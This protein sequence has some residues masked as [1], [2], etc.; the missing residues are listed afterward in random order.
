MG[1]VNAKKQLPREGIK[2]ILVRGTNWIGD[3]VMTLPAVAAIRQTYPKTAITVLAKP[4]VAEIYR[5]S[6]DV[7]HVLIFEEPGLH[8]GIMGKFRIASMLKA[9]SFD[10]AILLQNA[11]EAAIITWLADIPI[12]AGYDSDARGPLLTHP[13]HRTHAV[14]QIHQTDYYL[15]MA[16]ALGCSPP[17]H[18]V[19]LKPDTSCDMIAETL[20]KKYGLG[21]Q[22]SI[23][24]IAPGAAYGPAKRWFPDGFASVADRLVADLSAHIILFGSS[25]DLD[26]AESVRHMTRH[27]VINLAGESSL[28]EAIAMIACCS[29]FISN[30]S[31]LMHISAALGVPTVAIFGS[32]NPATTSPVGTNNI[33]VYKAVPCSPCLKP[34]CPTDFQCMI[35]ITPDDVYEAACKLL[36]NRHAP[37]LH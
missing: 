8:E 24:G 35:Q 36:L 28:R 5:L 29:L 17:T 33:V 37:L 10:I 22:D 3:A 32:T 25:G 12:R 2:K 26:S 30:D 23:I 31:G 15:E 4:W 21:P 7:D 20:L 11:I 27:T 1:I 9:A 13:V 34:V 19:I 14:R 6:P 18:G 16:K